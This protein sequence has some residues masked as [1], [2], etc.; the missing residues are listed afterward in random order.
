MHVLTPQRTGAHRRPAD[1]RERR[2]V[3]WRAL[4]V[5]GCLALSAAASAAPVLQVSTGNF[6]GGLGCLA[7]RVQESAIGPL[8]DTQFCSLS[9][10]IA[11]GTAQSFATADYG[12]LGAAVILGL[13]PAGGN[14]PGNQ[15][16]ASAQ[17]GGQYI[18][19]G[20]GPTVSVALNLDFD[21]SLNISGGDFS[22]AGMEITMM[23]PGLF[24]RTSAAVTSDR[25][26][27]TQD[28]LD[29]TVDLGVLVGVNGGRLD[30]RSGFFTVPVDVP[31]DI[32]LRLSTFGSVRS[33]GNASAMTA[34]ADFGSTLSFNRDGSVFVL[35][36]GF[37]VDGSGVV[38]NRW[39]GAPL[40]VP[41]PGS[42]ALAALGF[43]A[44]ARRSDRWARRPAC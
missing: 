18:F 19:K 43:A 27:V 36:A 32:I 34:V 20:S 44:L 24:G 9:G 4:L 33:T 16:T 28:S 7:T 26:L 40:T 3:L 5:G 25:G 11:Q 22:S 10:P 17:F 2:P 6:A 13:Q 23:A 42:L 37:T 39:V 8:S 29:G 12:S 15:G 35:P 21:G 41:E 31:V 30:L 14:T 38:D 1:H